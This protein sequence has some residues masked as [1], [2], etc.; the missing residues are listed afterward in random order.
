MRSKISLYKKKIED[1]R[2]EIE[3]KNFEIQE[4]ENRE[5]EHKA[6]CSQNLISGYLYMDCSVFRT[7]NS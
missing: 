7:T 2:E 5:K 1:Q 4:L 6:V 3:M